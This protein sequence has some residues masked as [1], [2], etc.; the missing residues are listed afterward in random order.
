MPII[1]DPPISGFLSILPKKGKVLVIGI[2]IHA[3][4]WQ[5]LDRGGFSERLAESWPTIL[6]DQNISRYVACRGQCNHT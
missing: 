1:P 3:Y 4:V 5:L 2:P 6:E